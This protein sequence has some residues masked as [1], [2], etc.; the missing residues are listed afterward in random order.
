MLSPSYPNRM[1]IHLNCLTYFLHPSS[2][3]KCRN[4]HFTKILPFQL[5]SCE[6]SKG[7]VSHVILR[8]RFHARALF[9][10]EWT[11]HYHTCIIGHK[12]ISYMYA[13]I[14][15]HKYIERERGGITGIWGGL[16]GESD[17]NPLMRFKRWGFAPCRWYARRERQVVKAFEERGGGRK[18]T[19][20][21]WQEIRLQPTTA[22]VSLLRSKKS[23]ALMHRDATTACIAESLFF[24]R[25]FE[26][27]RVNDG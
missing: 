18:C 7:G 25:V 22:I 14:V 16:G 6:P 23:R 26:W 13:H 27:R 3:P 19:A 15:T 4:K 12:A 24:G 20:A 17:K 1:T 10:L 11:K 21:L 2:Q 5:Q 8:R 9:D